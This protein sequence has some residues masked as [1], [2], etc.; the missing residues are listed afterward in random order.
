MCII[1][2]WHT[3][4][5]DNKSARPLQ[6]KVAIVFEKHNIRIVSIRL[7]Y[8]VSYYCSGRLLLSYTRLGLPAD[9]IAI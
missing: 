9:C 3:G 6:L 8:Y 5:S 7:Y 4:S 2:Q 1:D